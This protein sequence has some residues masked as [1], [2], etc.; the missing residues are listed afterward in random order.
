[1]TAFFIN[2]IVNRSP[3]V[4]LWFRTGTE[5]L[6]FAAACFEIYWR[7]SQPCR[8]WISTPTAKTSWQ[9]L[10]FFPLRLDGIVFVC[11]YGYPCAYRTALQALVVFK[12]LFC[13]FFGYLLRTAVIAAAGALEN[14]V[15]A[16]MFMFDAIACSRVFLLL[17]R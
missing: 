16:A 6:R 7:S 13:A 8:Y 4:S 15:F 1:M 5:T 10:L 11:H 2:G 3:A 12:P 9:K 17:F 14:R